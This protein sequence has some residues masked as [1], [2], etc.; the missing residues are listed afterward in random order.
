[1]REASIERR[2]VSAVERHG[3]RAPKWVS[4]GQRGVPDRIVILPDGGVAFVELK[5]PG[6]PLGP[7]QEKW[8]E[9]LRDLGHS[10]YRIDSAEGIDDFIRE[11][12]PR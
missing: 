7:L 3:G 2:F 9:R 6:K 8:A 12:F 10:V 4:P 5:A 11:V 1:M